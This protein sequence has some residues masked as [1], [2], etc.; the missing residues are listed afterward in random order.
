MFTMDY[1]ARAR[2]NKLRIERAYQ[3]RLDAK[4]AMVDA[5]QTLSGS[6]KGKYDAAVKVLNFTIKEANLDA[7]AKTKLLTELAEKYGSA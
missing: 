6:L 7:E 5:G 4:K 1:E 2:A 3:D